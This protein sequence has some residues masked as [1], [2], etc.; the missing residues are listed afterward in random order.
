MSLQTAHNQALRSLRIVSRKEFAALL[1]PSLSQ[2][3]SF[4]TQP[5]E[6][7]PPAPSTSPSA[8]SSSQT[9]PSPTSPPSASTASS[10]E[11]SGSSSR[12]SLS[13][14][15]PAPRPSPAPDSSSPKPF[16][17]RSRLKFSP[18]HSFETV[19]PRLPQ[20][21]GSNQRL[22]VP[23]ET[24]ALLEEIV[25]TFRAP[26]RYA[27]AY[28][29]G[30]FKQKGYEQ[31]TGDRPMLDFIFAVTHADHW[32][33]IN[34]EQF[35]SHYPLTARI[36]G[37]GLV[38]R[39]QNTGPGL[40]FNAYIPMNGATIKYGVT[41]VD[42]LTS[43]LLTWKTLYFSGRMHKPIRIIKDDPRIR[44]TQQVNL[45]HALRT[46]LL[47]LPA[48]FTERQLFETITEFSYAGDPR[49]KLPAENRSKVQNIVSLQEEWFHELYWK[50]ASGIPGVHW[51]RGKR[52]VE[53]DVD[54]KMKMAHLRKLPLNLLTHVE[55]RY[56]AKS[57]E[58]AA[59]KEGDEAAFWLKVASD[60]ELPTAIDSSLRDIVRGP[61]TVQS[62]K[63]IVTAGAFKS[64]RYSL[65]K[66]GKWWKGRS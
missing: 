35:P 59:M 53:Q 29:S 34:M 66:V 56:L 19:I 32:H 9:S 12:P 54:G 30:V 5:E 38:S 60:D 41:T 28:G 10:T 51:S 63:G 31:N 62:L 15:T 24:R 17:Y 27:F 44:L 36:A 33:S 48:E 22:P 11:G 46:A 39:F 1:G 25:G 57:P 16:T 3:R 64:A 65:T 42:T 8:T 20:Q 49:M 50:L 4:A 61:A 37:S 58:F 7:Q 47:V 23:D 55:Q 2:Y 18:D 6:Q 40:W 52:I 21:F 43:D 14:P 13:R 45:A 26:I